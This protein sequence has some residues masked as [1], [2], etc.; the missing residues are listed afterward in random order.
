MEM[1][2]YEGEMVH[3]ITLHGRIT[4]RA[5]FNEGIHPKVVNVRHGW[6]HPM[7]ANVNRLTGN[8]DYDPATGGPQLRGLL[9]RIEKGKGACQ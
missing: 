6:W 4:V 9:C 2:I 8:T 7:E 1:D 3:V 5:A